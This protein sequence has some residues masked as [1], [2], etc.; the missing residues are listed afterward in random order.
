MLVGAISRGR[1]IE[2]KPHED[3]YRIAIKYSKG[4]SYPISPIFLMKQE[5]RVVSAE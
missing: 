3:R 5:V 4:N 1:A 2:E